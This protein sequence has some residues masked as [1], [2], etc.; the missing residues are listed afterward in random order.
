MKRP[1]TDAE[2][3]AEEARQGR[4]LCRCGCGMHAAFRVTGIDDR[5]EAYDEG[6]CI[7]AAEYLAEESAECGVPFTKERLTGVPVEP[8][9]GRE[10][11]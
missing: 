7:S 5:G 11:A 10:R 2:W 3:R 8:A 6:A 9:P 1:T 4:P